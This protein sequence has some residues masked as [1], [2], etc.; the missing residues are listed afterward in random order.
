VCAVSFTAF[1]VLELLKHLASEGRT[2]V[3]TIHQPSSEI[4]GLFDRLILL[5]GGRVVF[6]GKA[7]TAV[8]WFADQGFPCPKYSN[9]SDFFMRILHNHSAEDKA[10]V[11]TL[12]TYYRAQTAAAVA[13]TDQPAGLAKQESS[14]LLSKALESDAELVLSEV[15]RP[16][17]GPGAWREIL[18]LSRRSFQSLVRNPI[19]LQARIAQNVVMALVAGL[20]YYNVGNTQSSVQNRIGAL[21][22]IVMSQVWPH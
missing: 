17:K 4:F 3:C 6:N 12:V 20:L 18:V 1:S 7:R 14:A 22:F 19:T 13:G 11:D 10:R 16:A 2:V 21:F 5:S 15:D 8:T 9:P